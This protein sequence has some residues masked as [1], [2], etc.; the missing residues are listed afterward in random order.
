MQRMA[1]AR[2]LCLSVAALFVVTCLAGCKD[3]KAGMGQQ[4]ASVAYEP[5]SNDYYAPSTVGG[6]TSDPY[7]GYGSGSTASYGSGGG[8]QTHMVTKGD[9]LYSLARAYYND[10]SKWRS[11]YEANRGTLS[12]P[13]KLRVG[14]EL[15]IP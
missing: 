8:G 4:S 6:Q 9:T 12:D 5:P 2:A 1:L 10:Q 7:A 11:I 3:K 13:N 14:Q 15:I